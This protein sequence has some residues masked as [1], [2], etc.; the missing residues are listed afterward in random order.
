VR[1]PIARRGTWVVL[2]LIGLGL[3]HYGLNSPPANG[4]ITG[5]ASPSVGPPITPASYQSP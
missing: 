3:A 5:V 1:L 4:A 2:F